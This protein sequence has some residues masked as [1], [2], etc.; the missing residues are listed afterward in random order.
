MHQ[1][2]P[3]PWPREDWSD[4]AADQVVVLLARPS[5]VDISTDDLLSVL[6]ADEQHRVARLR[7]PEDRRRSALGSALSRSLLGQWLDLPPTAV[8]LARTREGKPILTPAAASSGPWFNVS[9]SEDVVLVAF[10]R[11]GRVGVDVEEPRPLDDLLSVAA[12]AFVAAEVEQVRAATGEEQLAYFYRL[13]TR[14]EAI[15]K[16]LGIGLVGLDRICCD[17]AEHERNALRSLTM[18][19]EEAAAWCVR[20]LPLPGTPFPAAIAFEGGGGIVIVSL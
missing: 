12:T 3:H 13:W 7:R 18:E 6:S 2:L 8:P 10:S 20:T 9:H 5:A 14:K 15:A 16:A 11:F 4:C 1:G 19:G 17:G